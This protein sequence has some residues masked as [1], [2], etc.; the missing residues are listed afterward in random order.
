MSVV[1]IKEKAGIE[2]ANASQAGTAIKEQIEATLGEVTAS[3]R[4][5]LAR[6]KELTSLI[7]AWNERIKIAKQK[8]DFAQKN[9]PD[10]VYSFEVLHDQA[11]RYTL[12]YTE[13]LQEEEAY[14]LKIE[15]SI[16][17]L[18]AVLR[19]LESIEKVSLLDEKL[20]KITAGTNI[21]EGR[22]QVT[23]TREVQTLLHTAQALVELK[24]GK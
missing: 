13:Q 18:T 6:A 12:G 23:N 14:S 16:P 1:A 5:T 9:M 20:Q 2:K 24:K 10:A 19:Q 11:K 3:H 21:A 17:K 22:L 8:I 7:E 4:E 15:E